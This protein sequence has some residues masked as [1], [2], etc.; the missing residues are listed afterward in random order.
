LKIS[1]VP[2]PK[3]EEVQF[4]QGNAQNLNYQDVILEKRY[5][6]CILI[7]SSAF[8]PDDNSLGPGK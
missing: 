4:S 8:K 6:L 2:C 1:E 7:Y 5:K 3:T